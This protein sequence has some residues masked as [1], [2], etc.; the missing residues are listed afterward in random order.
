MI[1]YHTFDKKNYEVIRIGT[2]S[3][4]SH[5]IKIWSSTSKWWICCWAL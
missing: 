2:I 4:V 3:D 1:F 5:F